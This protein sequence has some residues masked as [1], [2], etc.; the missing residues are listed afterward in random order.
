MAYLAPTRRFGDASLLQ[1]NLSTQPATAAGFFSDPLGAL[2]AMET[3]LASLLYNAASGNVSS[4]EV[5]TIKAQGDA[6]IAQA[7]GGD[8]DLTAAE[9]T[10]FH[11]ELGTAVSQGYY[12][13][14]GNVL[15]DVGL[16]PNAPGGVSSTGILGWLET[17]WYWVFGAAAAFLIFRPDKAFR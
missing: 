8:P 3:D 16:D 11:N 13:G 10:Q 1:P 9:Q 17:N 6:A 15:A 5:A 14:A 12:S 7:A 4:S 2:G